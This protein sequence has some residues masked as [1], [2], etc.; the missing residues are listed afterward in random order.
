M[1][2]PFFLNLIDYTESIQPAPTKRGRKPRSMANPIAHI[3][4]EL[5][6][7]E[8][9]PQWFDDIVFG[10][11]LNS[12]GQSGN[13]CNV[14]MDEVTGALHL[15]TF[16]VQPLL[17][18]GMARRKAQRVIAAAR[19]AAHGLFTYLIRR[20][21]LL[22]RYEEEARIEAKLVYFHH[23]LVPYTP[24]RQVPRHIEE[25]RETGDYLAY[26]EALREFR[27]Q[28]TH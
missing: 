14:S 7:P 1:A 6:F 2:A 15:R 11:C 9:R 10:S 23:A 25:L 26:G 24:L 12:A 22:E 13:V 3:I 17:D 27:L 21:E 18:A 19:H 4:A 8:A 16:V 5:S 28:G 20:P